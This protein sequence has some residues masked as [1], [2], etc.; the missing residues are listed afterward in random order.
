MPNRSRVGRRRD[1]RWSRTLQTCGRQPAT[2]EYCQ[3]QAAAI[4]LDAANFNASV[5]STRSIGRTS[6]NQNLPPITAR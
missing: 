1:D 2:T 4:S 5:S 3:P 6:S